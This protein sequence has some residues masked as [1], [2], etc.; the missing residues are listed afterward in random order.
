[1][2]QRQDFWMHETKCVN[3]IKG[4]YVD[5]IFISTKDHNIL[6]IALQGIHKPRTKG[7]GQLEYISGYAH[8]CDRDGTL[9]YGPTS[10]SLRKLGVSK[11]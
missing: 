1:M 8:I 11:M 4:V 7:V 9:Y 3:D 10:T 2:H 5:E 6:F